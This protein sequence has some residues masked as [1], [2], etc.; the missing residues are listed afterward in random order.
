[1]STTSAFFRVPALLGLAGRIPEAFHLSLN[2]KLVRLTGWVSSSA[3]S[4]QISSGRYWVCLC[5]SGFDVASSVAFG[6]FGVGQPAHQHKP[7]GIKFIP[8]MLVDDWFGPSECESM[9]LAVTCPAREERVDMAAFTM[10]PSVGIR[11]RQT[12]SATYYRIKRDSR[13]ASK[14]HSEETGTNHDR[15]LG[16]DG[17]LQIPAFV[18]Y[19][20]TRLPSNTAYSASYSAA[21]AA[22]LVGLS[23]EGD[24]LSGLLTTPQYAAQIRTIQLRYKPHSPQDSPNSRPILPHNLKKCG[25]TPFNGVE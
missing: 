9:S 12:E 7:S 15:N 1:M 25:F 8:C 10:K 24:E 3:S 2:E 13:A 21:I 23:R 11:K 4:W 18:L 16:L 19:G 17:I 20:L 6:L 22:C 5:R 14:R